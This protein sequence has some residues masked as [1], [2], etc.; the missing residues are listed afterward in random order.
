MAQFSQV[1][2]V[3]ATTLRF[4]DGEDLV[5]PDRLDNGHRR[6]TPDHIARVEMVR[7]CQVLGAGTAE[8]R[9]ILDPPDPAA[10]VQYARERLPD[11]EQRVAALQKAV[12]VL[13]HMTECTHLTLAECGAWIE[14]VVTGERRADTPPQPTAATA[15]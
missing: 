15:L 10:R 5:T 3:P 2:G 1:V 6:Y 7:M 11:V 9:L 14:G 4:W 8:I 13:R 12:V